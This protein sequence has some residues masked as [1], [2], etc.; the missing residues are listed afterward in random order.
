MKGRCFV[1]LFAYG[2]TLA[3]SDKRRPSSSLV[4]WRDKK[5]RCKNGGNISAEDGGVLPVVDLLWP[6]TKSR[7]AGALLTVALLNFITTKSFSSEQI[8]VHLP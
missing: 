5:R 4:P 8:R 1:L 7:F 2:S 6:T 3:S